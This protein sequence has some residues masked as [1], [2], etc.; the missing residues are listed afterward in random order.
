M[1]NPVKFRRPLTQ[2]PFELVTDEPLVEPTPAPPSE[3]IDSSDEW[4]NITQENLNTLP[5]V[6]TRGLLYVLIALTLAILPWAM[7]SKVDE[8]GSASGRLEPK[9]KT[10]RL[11]AA[12]AGTISRIR[13][14]EGQQ[15]KA[16]ESLVELESTGIVNQLEEAEAKLNGQTDR[17][18]QLQL[19]RTQ[20]QM[21]QRTQ[22]QQ[23]QAQAL[24][25]AAQVT[26]TQD[27]LLANQAAI[28]SANELLQ[29]DQARVDR[30]RSLQ[31]QGVLSGSQV[32]DAERTMIENQQRLQQNQAELQQTRSEIQKQQSTYQRLLREGELAQINNLKQDQELQTQISDL[33]AEI[34]QTEKQ[35][36]SLKYQWQQ[37]ILHAPVDGT[38]FQLPLQNPGAVVQP[39]TLVA[40]VAPQGAPIVLRSQ[41]PSEDMGFLRVG[42]PVKVKFD[43]YPFQDY[44]IIPGRLTWISPD[45]KTIQVGQSRQE[46]FE[47][48]IELAQSYIQAANKRIP[49]TPGQTATAE[50]II[51]QRRVI[52]FFIDPFKQLQKGGVNF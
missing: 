6:W 38:V 5:Q 13:V 36:Q 30:F 48:E 46:V 7:F 34:A 45:S 52:D 24:E 39:G 3:P 32:E 19:M 50:V 22:Q 9:G 31:S 37:R 12:V 4:S 14:K 40:Q 18:A 23:T 25:Q 29:K 1:T 16:G 17:L 47:L 8:V 26:K 21:T 41:M 44:G 35:I 10:L 2:N 51:R 28:A 27:N 43:A 15:V 42:L 33:Q 49:L 11:D 20:Q